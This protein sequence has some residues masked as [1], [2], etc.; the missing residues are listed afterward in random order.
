LQEQKRDRPLQRFK[1]LLTSHNFIPI[2]PQAVRLIAPK[3]IKVST[4]LYPIDANRDPVVSP[5]FKNIFP[6][7]TVFL[8]IDRNYI[9]LRETKNVKLFFTKKHKNIVFLGKFYHELQVR[10]EK[11]PPPASL[12]GGNTVIRLKLLNACL[13]YLFKMDERCRR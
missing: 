4:L 8:L 13:F 7:T 3:L 10:K 2:G 12:S 11:S 9:T 6:V 5:F 1:D